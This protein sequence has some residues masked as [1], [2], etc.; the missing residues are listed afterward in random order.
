MAGTKIF[1]DMDGVVANFH[2]AALAAHGNYNVD[3]LKEYQIEKALGISTTKFWA[4]LDS[5]D[6]WASIP[7]TDYA[8]LL[9]TLLRGFKCYFLSSPALGY[10]ASGKLIWA[11]KH[12]PDIK[13]ILT[14]E[15]HLLAAPDR[16]LIDDL[17]SNIISWRGAGGKGILWPAPYNRLAGIDPLDEL[18][19]GM[20]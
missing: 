11:R 13:V 1:I 4:K 5:I 7:K 18:L 15:K 10:S 12:Y 3:L 17:E 6:F 9:I 8:D 20:R 16:I 2:Y 19:R 14:S